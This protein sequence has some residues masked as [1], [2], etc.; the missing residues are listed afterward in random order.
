VDAA[1]EFLVDLEDLAYGAVLP[2]GG[3]QARASSSTV[4]T[5]T[6]NPGLLVAVALPRARQSSGLVWRLARRYSAGAVRQVSEANV[7]AQVSLSCSRSSAGAT[8]RLFSHLP[9]GDTSAKAV[10]SATH[11]VHSA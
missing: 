4:S 5:T 8:H 2:V 7:G 10:K 11:K 6:T 9:R 1:G 3:A